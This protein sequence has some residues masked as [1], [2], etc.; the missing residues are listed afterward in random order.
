[1]PDPDEQAVQHEFLCLLHQLKK[2]NTVIDDEPLC[3]LE[4]QIKE[5]CYGRSIMIAMFIIMKITCSLV[6][7][8]EDLEDI[9]RYE[10]MLTGICHILDESEEI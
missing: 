9:K 3:A 4:Y 1:M 10:D 8:Q 6:L 7:T 2:Y 5:G